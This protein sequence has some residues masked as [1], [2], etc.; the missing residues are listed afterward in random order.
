MKLKVEWKFFLKGK[1]KMRK[2]IYLVQSLG[3]SPS[4]SKPWSFQSTQLDEK[5]TTTTLILR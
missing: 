3:I 4:F 1:G 5:E 2:I